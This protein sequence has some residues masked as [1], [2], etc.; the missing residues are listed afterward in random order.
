MVVLFYFKKKVRRNQGFAGKLPHHNIMSHGQF[1][2]KK[3]LSLYT[4]SRLLLL[5]LVIF[6]WFLYISQVLIKQIFPIFSDPH[7][8]LEL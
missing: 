4:T 2:T 6:Y 3:D 5:P 1:D 8:L 7:F